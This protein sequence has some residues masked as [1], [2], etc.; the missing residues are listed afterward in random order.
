MLKY[1]SYTDYDW[2]W[3]VRHGWSDFMKG[4]IDLKDV[5]DVEVN[6]VHISSLRNYMSF[7]IGFNY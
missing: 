5:K 3:G 6:D 2:I 7:Y 4:R 1:I